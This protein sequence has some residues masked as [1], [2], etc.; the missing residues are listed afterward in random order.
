MSELRGSLHMPLCILLDSFINLLFLTNV[1]CA[2]I[3]FYEIILLFLIKYS[4][5]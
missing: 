1:Y 2:N 3:F 5:A 4:F